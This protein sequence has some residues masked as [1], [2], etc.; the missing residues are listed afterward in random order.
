MNIV[1]SFEMETFFRDEND[2]D[3]AECEFVEKRRGQIML[4]LFQR[5]EGD[6]GFMYGHGG[7]GLNNDCLEV[8]KSLVSLLQNSIKKKNVAIH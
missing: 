2:M 5:T 8:R 4:K 6:A 3:E 7:F 1:Y